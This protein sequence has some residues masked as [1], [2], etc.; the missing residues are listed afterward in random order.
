MLAFPFLLRLHVG[1]PGRGVLLP[2]GFASSSCLSTCRAP[3]RPRSVLSGIHPGR[4]VHEVGRVATNRPLLS[5]AERRGASAP[6]PP[7]G[8]QAG[9]AGGT[10]LARRRAYPGHA[11]EVKT[12][13]GTL[14]PVRAAIKAAGPIPGIAA[15]PPRVR[16]AS[17]PGHSRRPDPCARPVN[18]TDDTERHE[19]QRQGH[20]RY[21]RV[22]SL[23]GRPAG[24]SSFK[25]AAVQASSVR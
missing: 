25:E 7:N 5:P 10:P 15:F 23:S 8:A 14:A 16:S 6:P 20:E 1:D 19:G 18:E 21:S 4:P 12:E 17:E 3:P 24:T 22:P 13:G 11:G 2:L 9:V